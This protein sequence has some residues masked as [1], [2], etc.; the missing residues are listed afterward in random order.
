MRAGHVR[1]VW[2]EVSSFGD[3]V[4]RMMLVVDG[5][6]VEIAEAKEF[7]VHDYI[8]IEEFERRVAQALAHLDFCGATSCDVHDPEFPPL[9]C[10]RP[11]GHEGMHRQ[12]GRECSWLEGEVG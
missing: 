4:P 1:D 2:V 7:Y 12:D 5:R 6:E 8:T 3:A 9:V 10:S 11:A